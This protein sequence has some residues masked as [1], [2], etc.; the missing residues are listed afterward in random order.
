MI[1]ISSNMEYECGKRED[2]DA[3]NMKTSRTLKTLHIPKT[4][5]QYMNTNHAAIS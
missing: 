1:M 5:H 4:W 2:L 3:N